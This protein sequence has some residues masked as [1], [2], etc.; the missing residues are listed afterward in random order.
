MTVQLSEAL[1]ELA[2]DPPPSSGSRHDADADA[3]R[4]AWGRSRVVR[5]R[6]RVAGAAAAVVAALLVVPVGSSLSGLRAEQP[7]PGE[8]PGVVGIPDRLY[9][10]SGLFK[11]VSKDPVGPAALVVTS[12]DF[13]V[14]QVVVAAGS[15][16][17]RLLT[18]PSVQYGTDPMVL[19]SERFVALSRDGRR[20]AVVQTTQETFGGP[21]VGSVSLVSLDTGASSVMTY[22]GVV[23]N[24]AIF[25][26]DGDQL[27]ISGD[28]VT[29]QRPDGYASLG[30]VL[31]QDADGSVHDLGVAWAAL[32]WLPDGELVLT[33]WSP[34]GKPVAIK[35]SQTV[36]VGF[37]DGVPQAPRVL[38]PAVDIR[39]NMGG[40]SALSPDGRLVAAAGGTSNSSD[41]SDPFQLVVTRVSDGVVVRTVDWTDLGDVALVGWQ[42]ASTPVVA[43]QQAWASDVADPFTLVAEAASGP[44]VLTVAAADARPFRLATAQ[45]LLAT[46]RV[47]RSAGA[48]CLVPGPG[49]RRV[50]C[51]RLVRHDP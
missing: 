16:D 51:V 11:S 31:V 48:A 18:V 41:G 46:V 13:T 35:D 26:P 42:D 14:P 21:M 38:G 7:L 5:R 2:D 22:P 30:H 15:D 9:A 27:A 25:S 28:V 10:S 43:I 4:G 45:D 37:T 3:A 50:A 40:G 8:V 24:A 17:Y 49:R 33:G 32:G 12:N 29:E 44:E 20:A 34:T 6:R 1:R 39:G 36:A 47:G 23:L 19:G